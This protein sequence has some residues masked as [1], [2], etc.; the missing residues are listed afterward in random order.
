MSFNIFRLYL[1]CLSS[2]VLGA[3]KRLELKSGEARSMYTKSRSQ[4]FRGPS[5]GSSACWV[6]ARMDIH[7]LR[8]VLDDEGD[9]IVG[10]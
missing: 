8:T 9:S 7:G 10:F 3:G 4:E 2:R 1:K 6:F 5:Q